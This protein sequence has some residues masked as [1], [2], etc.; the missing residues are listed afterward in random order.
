MTDHEKPSAS[1]NDPRRQLLD[2]DPPPVHSRRQRP[3]TL[4]A[5]AAILF[6]LILIVLL[7][8]DSGVDQR[9]AVD[10]TDIPELIT[11]RALDRESEGDDPFA[12]RRGFQPQLARG[13]WI[14]IA[15]EDG[16]LAQQYRCER[17]DPRPDGWLD[18]TQPEMEIYLQRN[19]ILTLRGDS[20]IAHAPSNAIESGT[21]TGNVIVKLFEAPDGT[22]IDVRNDEPTMTVE[23]DEASFDN[24]LGEIRC[25]DWV[26]ITTPQLEL[27][28]RQLSLLHDDRNN[29]FQL[30]IQHYDYIRLFDQD[31]TAVAE[32]S[33]PQNQNVDAPMSG[34]RFASQ[35]QSLRVHPA[36]MTRVEPRPTQA[37]H[38]HAND[39]EAT[40][41][42]LTLRERVRIDQGE[43]AERRIAVGERM[44]MIFSS[45]SEGLSDQPETGAALSRRTVPTVASPIQTDGPQPRST[46]ERLAMLSVGTTA[47]AENDIE[48]L[49]GPGITL[50]RGEG[51]LTILPLEDDDRRRPADPR[52]TYVQLTG[53][54]VLLCD[55]AGDSEATGEMFTYITTNKQAEL[56]GSPSHPLMLD[57]PELA[58]GGER[59][60]FRDVDRAGGFVGPGWMISRDRA[61]GER[62]LSACAGLPASAVAFAG[63]RGHAPP[64]VPD[65]EPE[66]QITWEEGM[67]LIFD[68]DDDSDGRIRE[69]IFKGNVRV[70]AEEFTLNAGEMTVGFPK[71]GDADTRAIE[72]IHAR[73]HVRVMGVG[74]ESGEI[75]SRDLHLTLERNTDGETIPKTM[76]AT[77]EVQAMEDDHIIWSDSLHVTFI[78]RTEAPADDAEAELDD[79][80]ERADTRRDRN[81]EVDKLIA[82]TDVQVLLADGTRA[83]ADRLD[84]DGIRETLELTGDNVF[85]VSDTMIMDQGRR[86]ILD[87][88]AGTATSPGPGQLRLYEQ[89][90]VPVQRERIRRPVVDERN[91]RQ[92]LRVRWREQMI[93][94]GT[95]NDGAGSVDFRGDVAAV[96]EPSPIERSTMTGQSLVLE[97]VHVETEPNDN[98][99]ADTDNHG[100]AETNSPPLARASREL[101]L[102]LARRDAKLESHTW[103]D[104]GREDEPNIFYVAGQHV[105]YHPLASEALVVGDGELLIHNLHDDGNRETSTD[106]PFGS[107]GSTMMTWS[108]QLHMTNPVDEIYQLVVDGDITARHRD[109]DGETSWMTCDRLDATIVRELSEPQLEARHGLDFGGSSRLERLKATGGV[110]VNTDHRDIAC[111]TFDYDVPSGIGRATAE[112]P[113]VVAIQ[114]MGSPGVTTAQ[115]ILWNM[116]RDTIRI[117]Q[118]AGAGPN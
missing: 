70:T 62:G 85:I 34:S 36:S 21:V 22:T 51:P 69:A 39:T 54:P 104:A 9:S 107:R 90:V 25:D 103:R 89:S 38:S 43:P 106:A 37:T 61:P 31:A 46:Y 73:E 29:R 27:P 99:E 65:D 5:C 112:R 4:I 93:Y 45:E 14:Q 105:E 48:H 82:E 118:P 57:S 55:M 78:E 68:N 74:A 16:Q 8:I 20:A 3:V 92:E 42:L 53:S 108:R 49:M 88:N 76:L 66:L 24:F 98:S 63:R 26:T 115:E 35:Q 109:L 83:F 116:E 11:P 1:D 117:L 64:L 52:D 32:A 97:F 79:R 91:N 67:D 60:R 84:G 15:G 59:F 110:N 96:A 111:D 102:L 80:A 41:Y 100:E 95:F 13:G 71:D 19:R 6:V 40:F 87:R 2:D 18:M 50:V 72:S 7:N 101:S 113:N 28:G 75:Q 30:R 10:D 23:T 94:D 86:L 47:G 77:G 114:T 12:L 33:R 58:A 56:I 81:V 44:E 17:L